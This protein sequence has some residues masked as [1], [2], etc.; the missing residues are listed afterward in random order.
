MLI[1]NM[2]IVFKFKILLKKVIV[3]KKINKKKLVL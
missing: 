3:I 1:K 2:K